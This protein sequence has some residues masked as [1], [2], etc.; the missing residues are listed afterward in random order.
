MAVRERD[1]FDARRLIKSAGSINSS[2]SKATKVG[3]FGGRVCM[4]VLGVDGRR[5]VH[6]H[7]RGIERQETRN[8]NKS[9]EK[10]VE[11]ATALCP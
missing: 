8:P 11:G 4:R 2:H 9:L 1:C 10:G 5:R 6:I 3:S 7:P